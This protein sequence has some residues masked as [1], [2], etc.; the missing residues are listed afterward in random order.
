MTDNKQLYKY[1]LIEL[2]KILSEEEFRGIIHK[3]SGYLVIFD[4][5]IKSA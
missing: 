4:E 1:K 3:R 2:E 5:W